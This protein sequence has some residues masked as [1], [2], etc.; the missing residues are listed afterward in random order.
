MT[1][2]CCIYWL[3]YPSPSRP[4]HPPS[5]PVAVSFTLLPSPPSLSSDCCVLR[6]PAI[7]TLP[8]C[9]GPK[10]TPWKRRWSS[11]GMGSHLSPL[12]L[13]VRQISQSG[14]GVRFWLESKVKVL[15]FVVD[16]RAKVV[17]L[18]RPVLCVRQGSVWL[19]DL[20]AFLSAH[21]TDSKH[22]FTTSFPPNSKTAVI[23]CTIGLSGVI[24]W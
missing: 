20:C 13:T 17:R 24:F 21:V 3:L 15:H 9:H 14:S 5:P 23:G 1:I 10:R 8:V 6:P 7:P 12:T 19:S 16:E 11:R 2:D 18:E 4:P 22:W